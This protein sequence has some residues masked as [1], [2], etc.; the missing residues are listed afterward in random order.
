MR[1]HNDNGDPSQ[2][3]YIWPAAAN[4]ARASLALRLVNNIF[5]PAGSVSRLA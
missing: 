5:R 1:D 2:E 3:A 4:A